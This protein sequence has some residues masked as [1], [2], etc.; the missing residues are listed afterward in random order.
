MTASDPILEQ[1]SRADLRSIYTAGREAIASAA[2]L[3]SLE[4]ARVHFLGRKA[5]LVLLLRTIP[6]LP[7]E[8]RPEVG[9]VGNL[10]RK[11][12]EE[13]VEA[14]R[15]E[16]ETQELVHG[17]GKDHIDVTLPGWR[18]PLGHLHLVTQTQREIEDIFVAMGYE[19]ADGPEIETDYYNF[20]ALNYTP[21][22]PL[23]R[24]TTPSS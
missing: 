15:V 7:A 23:G 17:L 8:E 2:D 3:A 10:I 5:E 13:A 21:I 22:I 11:A 24:C 1:V 12:L 20:E 19:V 14:R 4:A 18:S 9:K 6:E 16:L